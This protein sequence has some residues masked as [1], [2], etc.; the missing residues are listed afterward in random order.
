M[1][2][3]VSI[4]LSASCRISFQR[5]THRKETYA[6]CVTHWLP[7]NPPNTLRTSR[8]ASFP[9]PHPPPLA[10]SSSRASPRVPAS[11]MT[12]TIGTRLVAVDEEPEV[13]IA[14]RVSWNCSCVRA[15]K[16][17]G[18]SSR[19]MTRLR[20]PVDAGW[21]GCDAEAEVENR[22]LHADARV[23]NAS[24]FAKRV[25]LS[26]VYVPSGSSS[27]YDRVSETC[28]PFRHSRISKPSSRASTC[29]VAVFAV[30]AGPVRA[31]ILYQ[32]F[33][34]L[35]SAK[36]MLE[37]GTYAIFLELARRPTLECF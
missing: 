22:L 25:S 27:L 15:C 30:P 8:T 24:N 32:T 31:N 2:L 33:L 3:R 12:I 19:S 37:C 13:H 17:L 36:E 21:D 10:T 1:K 14:V 16:M 6:I 35:K 9:P 11:L 18:R 4:L 7:S 29:M 5:K 34:R 23:K 26:P 28:T 20:A